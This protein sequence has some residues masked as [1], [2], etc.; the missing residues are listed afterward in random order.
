MVLWQSMKTKVL[1]AQANGGE[2]SQNIESN[3]SIDTHCI[4]QKG[5]VLYDLL[6][7]E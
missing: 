2:K 3:V 6:V 1:S 4:E 5:E 7:L